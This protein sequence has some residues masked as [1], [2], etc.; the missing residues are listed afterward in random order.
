MKK[1]LYPLLLLTL[2]SCGPKQKPMSAAELKAAYMQSALKSDAYKNAF[3]NVKRIND[4]LDSVKKGKL[5]TVVPIFEYNNSIATATA[6]VKT[7]AQVAEAMKKDTA[8]L[9]AVQ[10]KAATDSALADKRN[11]DFTK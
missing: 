6:Q 3:M 9:K 1:L 7:V 11:I 2:L 8:Y 10:L 4:A 5:D